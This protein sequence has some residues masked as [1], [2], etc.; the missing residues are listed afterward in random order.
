MDSCVSPECSQDDDPLRSL[1]IAK[2]LTPNRLSLGGKFLAI[3]LVTLGMILSLFGWEHINMD[4]L[5]AGA[6]T[7]A[8]V[9]API[10]A[11]HIVGNL[12]APWSK[13]AR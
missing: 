12:V 3:L 11:S 13:H 9:G 6:W 1:S 10:D 8:L 2:W 5:K 7:L 4:T